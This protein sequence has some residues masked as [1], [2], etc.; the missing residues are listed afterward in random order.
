[1]IDV[2]NMKIKKESSR[3]YWLEKHYDIVKINGFKKLILPVSNQNENVKLYVMIEEIFD[4]LH[5][6]HISI[7][8][9]GR[10]RMLYEINKHYKN[11]TQS[12]VK[13]YLDLCIPCQQKKKK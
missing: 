2:K 7:G 8:H 6:I 3:D 1:M 12:D 10:D 4:Y 11:I 13:Q 5:E 9:G